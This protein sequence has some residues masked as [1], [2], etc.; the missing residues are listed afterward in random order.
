[1]QFPFCTRSLSYAQ[2]NIV[3]GIHQNNGGL[4]F[5]DPV[6]HC[7]AAALSNVGIAIGVNQHICRCQ[8]IHIFVELNAEYLIL[9]DLF[10]FVGSCAVIKRLRHCPHKERAATT[11][12]V[13]YDRVFIHTG[14]LGHKISNVVWSERLIF[15]RLSNILVECNE[16]QI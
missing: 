1:M 4:R 2:W 9:F 5:F 13:Q 10:L 16:E 6:C 12:R 15:I 7:E 11:T 8:T 14:N 3:G